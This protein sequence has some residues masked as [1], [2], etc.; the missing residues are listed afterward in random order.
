MFIG[1]VFRDSCKG[2]EKIERQIVR[3]TVVY[4]E[5]DEIFGCFESFNVSVAFKESFSSVND[6]KTSA[7]LNDR[8]FIFRINLISQIERSSV[9]VG[10]VR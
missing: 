1:F 6:D 4:G 10:I 5:I 9:P 7:Y 8:I 3:H 2:S